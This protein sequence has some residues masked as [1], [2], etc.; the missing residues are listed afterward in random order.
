MTSA[1][2]ASCHAERP[3]TSSLR[4]GTRPFHTRRLRL[5]SYQELQ[6]E[7]HAESCACR[8]RPRRAGIPPALAEATRLGCA[9]TRSAR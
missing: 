8:W 9:R 6:W 5:P 4:I 1:S 2:A 7:C 3:R